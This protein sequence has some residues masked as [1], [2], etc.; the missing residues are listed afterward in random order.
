MKKAAALVATRGRQ[1]R[2]STFFSRS[3]LPNMLLGFLLIAIAAFLVA[4][5]KGG[6]MQRF[7]LIIFSIAMLSAGLGAI[8]YRMN[9]GRCADS[10]SLDVVD[11]PPRQAAHEFQPLRERSDSEI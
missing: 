4:F 6:D 7:V 9:P 1:T 8:F 10:F 2:P 5:V 11:G 3:V